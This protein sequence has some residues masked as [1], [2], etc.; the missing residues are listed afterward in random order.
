MKRINKI[1]ICAL[2]GVICTI[3][4]IFTL[5]CDIKITLNL[6]TIFLI[7]GGVFTAILVKEVGK[8]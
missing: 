6:P 5:P 7:L 8:Y 1:D 4:A 3:L 2:L